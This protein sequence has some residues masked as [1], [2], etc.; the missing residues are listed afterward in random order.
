MTDRRELYQD[1]LD[2]VREDTRGAERR[3]PRTVANR[4]FG[5]L[6]AQHASE[7]SR[8][9]VAA[10]ALNNIAS[11]TPFLVLHVFWFGGWILLNTGVFGNEPWDP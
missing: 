2:M 11:S 9:E 3:R 8:L 5:A 1:A 4:A 6:K 10:D 7:R